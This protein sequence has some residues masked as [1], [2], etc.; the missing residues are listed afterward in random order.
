MTAWGRGRRREVTRAG[1]VSRLACLVVYTIARLYD[2][3]TQVPEPSLHMPVCATV[4]GGRCRALWIDIKFC[5]FW[6]SVIARGVTKLNCT[7]HG[8]RQ[9]SVE[10]FSLV[11]A[12][13]VR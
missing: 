13:G 7:T 11:I 1:D 9:R 2:L 12:F 6:K 3:A 4:C 8:S 5:E 10:R